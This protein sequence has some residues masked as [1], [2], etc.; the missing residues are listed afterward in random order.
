MRPG[1]LTRADPRA[2]L[3][4]VA[5]LLAGI[6][7]SRSW[8][9][10][11]VALVVGN[12]SY[13][14]LK[15]L[16]NPAND[17]AD[18][19]AALKARGFEVIQGTDVGGAEM[20]QLIARFL[21]QARRADVSMVYYAGHGF[22]VAQ[23][24]YLV[25]VD[26][27]IRSRQDIAAQTLTLRSLIDPLE[28]TPGIHLVFLDAC[29]NNPLR[30][31]GGVED[32]SLQNGLARVGDASGSL[33]AY[34][35]KP[36]N[37]AFD[38]G[39]RNS[40]FAQAMLSHMGTRGQDIAAM[41]I[42][43]RKDVLA[44]TGGFQMPSEISSLTRQFYF[45]PGQPAAISAET[46]LWQ[47]ANAVR[48]PALMRIYLARYPEGAHSGEAQAA[49]KLASAAPAGADAG[50]VRSTPESGKVVDDPLWEF[51]QRSRMRPLVEFYLA[52]NPDG[53]HA[54]EA[55][56][57]LQTLPSAAEIEREPTLLCE[58]SATHPRDAT[59]NTP[60]VPLSELARN[61][62]AAIVAC[63]EARAAHPETP[64]Y[65]ALLARALAAAGR[66]AESVAMYRE[67]AERGNL[68]AMVSLGL[69]MQTGDGMPAD[70]RGATALYEKAAEAGSPDGAI[71]LAVDLMQG[72]SGAKDPKRAVALLRQAADAGSA[73]A[74]YNL[75]VL[76]QDGVAG[77]RG[78]ALDLFVKATEL[79][80]PR[81]YV[82]AAILL[83]EGRG[84]GKDPAKAAEM[85]LRGIASD[86]GQA[87]SEIVQRSANWSSDTM[88][89]VQA[90][91]KRAGYYTGQVDGRGGAKMAMALDQWR[92]VGTLEIDGGK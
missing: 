64:Q 89:A 68:R 23:Q 39:G 46:Q 54:A 9:D 34:A 51:A 1:T 66:R 44:A 29:R 2:I 40:P 53:R 49:V 6:V 8:A 3:A 52:R 83:D 61:A 86:S 71:N 45:V 42:A 20:K 41:M 67:A 21:D 47:L 16:K 31:S 55:R 88:R 28:A 72:T 11:R 65:T 85:L 10:T 58:Q 75:G 26:A 50:M 17:A 14:G 74:T 81:G 13:Q 33:I 73:I 57:L 56:Q 4:C 82:P 37:V 87:K 25:P 27:A 38:G 18:I 84:I 15:P 80:D 79:G 63:R 30:D 70:P 69:L 62:P 32:A 92:R 43:V 7:P 48:E 77:E 5:L 35:T 78:R 36:D 24:N 12:S 76:T 19:A 90:R 91:L 22:Q 59:A 60:G